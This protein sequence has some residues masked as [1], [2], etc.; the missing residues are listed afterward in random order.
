MDKNINYILLF[1][2]ILLLVLYKNKYNKI[3]IILGFIIILYLLYSDL[4]HRENFINPPSVSDPKPK[5][6]PVTDPKPKIPP[7]TETKPINGEKLNSNNITYL[8]PN[9]NNN[10]NVSLSEELQTF[11]ENTKNVY[12]DIS[13]GLTCFLTSFEKNSF[14]STNDWYDL[15][16]NN[17]NFTFSNNSIPLNYGVKLTNNYLKGPYSNLLGIKA[18]KNY[19]ISM[20]LNILTLT[21]G[22]LFRLYGNVPGTVGDGNL[23]LKLYFKDSNLQLNYSGNGSS[24]ITKSILRIGNVIDLVDNMLLTLTKNNNEIKIYKN[25]NL[26]DV[27]SIS[28]YSNNISFSN[29]YM[30]I[31]YNKQM[32]FILYSLLIYNKEL[33]QTNIKKIYYLLQHQ[34]INYNIP[35]LPVLE[36]GTFIPEYKCTGIESELNDVLNKYMKTVDMNNNLLNELN[37]KNKKLNIINE[38]KNNKNKILRVKCPKPNMSK[39]IRKDKIPCFGCNIK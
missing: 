15:T 23:V 4:Y 35:N 8:S 7:V 22:E 21:P 10:N 18:D 39:Y 9:Y 25:N 30:Y 5:I 20:Y 34:F 38:N 36:D 1:F 14:S 32:D 27:I 2:V 29:E 28:Q 31:N 11:N 16:L 6:P 37:D 12:R 19:S 26:I 13:N 17:K 24:V 3:Y 33:D